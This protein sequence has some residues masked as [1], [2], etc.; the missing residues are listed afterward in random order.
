MQVLKMETGDGNI[1]A[2]ELALLPLVPF[3]EAVLI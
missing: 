1:G 2:G 3:L